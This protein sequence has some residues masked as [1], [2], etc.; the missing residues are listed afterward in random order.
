MTD[1]GSRYVSTTGALALMT[2]M[3]AWAVGPDALAQSGSDGHR[4]PVTLSAS[5]N[6]AQLAEIEPGSPLI[7]DV[8]VL[9]RETARERLVPFALTGPGGSWTGA[10]RLVAR[11]EEG[12]VLAWPFQQAGAAPGSLVLDE[13]TRG[14]AAWLLAPAM[15][16]QIA[17]GTYEIH[18]ILGAEAFAEQGLR[19]VR[20]T[21]LR[22]T[23][24][25]SDAASPEQ[26]ALGKLLLAEYEVRLNNRAEALEHIEDLVA[27]QPD[28][29][30]ALTF[31]GSLLAADGQL[32]A[33]LDAYDRAVELFFERHPN[34]QEPPVGLLLPRNTLLQQFETAVAFDV[35]VEPKSSFHPHLAQGTMDGYA[36]DGISGGELLLE[37]GVTYSFRMKDVPAAYPFYLT[38]SSSG[39]GAEPYTA[40]VEGAPA[41]GTDEV[42]FTPGP[43]TPEVLY[44]Q[45]TTAPLMGWRIRIADALLGASN[46]PDLPGAV[47][48]AFD[49]S[50][51]FPNPAGAA[52]QLSVTVRMAQHVR[53]DIVDLFGRQ[54]MT[55]HDDF[56][57]AGSAQ[58]LHIGVEGLASGVYFVRAHGERFAA[59]R[60]FVVVR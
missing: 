25:A 16:A 54:V 55:V 36:M 7:V 5:V 3:A 42:L 9:H 26:Q 31:R 13:I 11:T 21:P 18:V 2:W 30:N 29:I 38:M 19:D 58:E 45:S 56:V 14:Q 53:I 10:V 4:A 41:S 43:E 51:P 47:P 49:L 12:E 46:E 60:R 24:G 20:S 28:Y 8:F 44:Y 57:A 15:T 17:P 6:G 23:V 50:A 40:G 37:R 33:A 1:S 32:L 34:P 35:T 48:H 22:V 39:D 52:F 59:Y 27:D